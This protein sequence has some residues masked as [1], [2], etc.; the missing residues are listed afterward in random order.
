MKTRV[1]VCAVLLAMAVA[2]SAC[3]KKKPAPPAPAPPVAE[4]PRTT[5]PP[6]PPPPPPAPRETPT[7]TPTE[8]EVFASKSLEQL[9]SEHPLGDAYFDLDSSQI[10]NDAQP[11]LQK[12]ADWLKRWPSTKVT[13]E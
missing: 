11:A 5:T 9:N 13:V 4:T 2:V 1:Q 3:G 6:P 8:E 10:R 12:D 7:R